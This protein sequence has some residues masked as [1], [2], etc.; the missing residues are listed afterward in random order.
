MK[1]KKERNETQIAY[2][3]LALT[4]LTTL[5]IVGC[6]GPSSS[7]SAVTDDGTVDAQ[8]VSRRLIEDKSAELLTIME[9][10]EIWVKQ[11]NIGIYEITAEYFDI[12]IPDIPFQVPDIELESLTMVQQES[13]IEELD[14]YIKIQAGLKPE[15]T[16]MVFDEESIPEGY[17]ESKDFIYYDDY[18]IEKSRLA[19]Y[20][21]LRRLMFYAADLEYESSPDSR[22]NITISNLWN[23]D[24]YEFC[25][26]DNNF[27]VFRNGEWV[28]ANPLEYNEKQ[29][30]LEELERWEDCPNTTFTM[31]EEPDNA[32]YRTVWTAGT[33]G[34]VFVG[35]YQDLGTLYGH[36]TDSIWGFSTHI[37]EGRSKQAIVFDEDHSDDDRTPLHEIG[38]SLGFYHEM[39]RIDAGNYLVNPQ[40]PSRGLMFGPFDFDSI[41]IKGDLE[42]KPPY[43]NDGIPPDGDTYWTEGLSASDKAAIAYMY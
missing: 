16:V 20:E 8:T 9:E 3:L 23:N 33:F 13:L 10:T 42:I 12:Q 4:I 30:F 38:H 21:V 5:L 32:F 35:E 28:N 34:L 6:D 31:D 27:E 36:S 43:D 41:M 11:T 25:L 24:W 39:E 37:G 1:R 18:G 19:D 26:V 29:K 2:Y 15:M 17:S 14:A 40:F 22:A 7:T